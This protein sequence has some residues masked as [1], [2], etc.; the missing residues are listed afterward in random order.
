MTLS[1]RALLVAPVLASPLI[2]SVSAQ[3][4]PS[5]TI[6]VI[7]PGPA[8]S[9]R[10]LRARWVAD[11]LGQ[12][13]ER[14]IIVDNKPGA[15][16]NIGMEAAA[17]SAPDG[18]SLVIVDTGTLAQNPHI[19]HRPGY[20]ARADFAPVI[21]LI[22]APLLLCVPAASPLRKVSELVA[23]AREK[24]GKLYFGSPGIA[25]PPHLA[26]ELFKRAAGIDV[27]HVP[28]KGAPPAIQDLV[29]GRLDFVIDNIAL[30]QPL[31]AGGKVRAIAVSS[32][33]RLENL[34]GVP[35]IAEAGLQGATY[36]P[37]MGVAAPAST[38]A[39]LIERLNRA[40]DR[41]L[42]SEAGREWFR[43]QGATILGGSPEDFARRIDADYRRWGEVI[44]AAEIKPE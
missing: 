10:D 20:D 19:Y 31:V 11:R 25:T 28:Y 42:A 17:R 18:R 38:P 32:A 7:A 24:P 21:N 34:P 13:L 36:V 16:G 23:L 14:I 33:E 12:A 3:D 2:A 37:W 1:R 4:Y 40:L 6:R 9:P 30:L 44:R 5:G 29:G 35:S 27:V 43:A 26:A 41:A 15:G 22:E 39:V 8:G